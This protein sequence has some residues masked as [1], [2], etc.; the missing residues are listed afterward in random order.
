MKDD[1]RRVAAAAAERGEHGAA[2][3]AYERAGDYLEAA[4]ARRSAGEATRALEDLVHVEHNDPRYR[5][6]CVLAIRLASE[7]NQPSLALENFLARFLHSA[8]QNDKEEAALLELVGLYERHG[9]VENASEALRKLVERRPD[10]LEA[11][12]RLDAL[13]A[14]PPPELPDLPPLPAEDVVSSP[15]LAQEDAVDRDTEEE[16]PFREGVVVGGRYRL[17]KRVGAGATSV[18]FRAVDLDLGDDVAVKVLTHAVFDPETDARLRRELMLSR[19][20]IHPNVVRVFEMGLYRGFR[21]ITMELLIGGRLSERFHSGTLSLAEGLDYLAQACAGLQAAHDLGI[22]HRDVK[23]SNCFIVRGGRL[24]VMDFGIAKVRDAPGLT[25]SGVIAGTPAYMAPE[26]AT[27]FRTVTPSTD[28][29]ALGVLAFEMFTLTLPFSHPDPLQILLRHR[30]E[31]P[32]PPRSI[33][34]SL[35]L[36]LEKII[37]TCLEKSPARRFSS[38]RELGRRVEALRISVRQ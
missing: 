29:Y 14:P 31:L 8:P 3:E 13:V 26:Q 28:V 20:L 36:E 1:L 18:V 4:N 33:N 11:R 37:L 24:K 16:P 38:C 5:Q 17:E 12:R 15:P 34:P 35:P 32:P 21:Y 10:D 9:F 30:D 7:K 25:T 19:Q 27:D 2:A 22:V 23:P 6:A